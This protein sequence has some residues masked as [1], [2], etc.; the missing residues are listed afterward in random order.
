MIRMSS[1]PIFSG[2]M[3]YVFS[4]FLFNDDICDVGG[5][6]GVLVIRTKKYN[7]SDF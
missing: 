6:D 1:I 3:M 5:K 2:W 7:E 4:G